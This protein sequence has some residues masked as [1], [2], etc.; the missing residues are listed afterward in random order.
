[1]LQRSQAG[2]WREAEATGADGSL[3]EEGDMETRKRKPWIIPNSA[4]E[5]C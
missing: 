5:R 3:F 4:F 1:M 2:R